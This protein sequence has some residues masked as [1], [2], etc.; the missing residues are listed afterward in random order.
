[1]DEPEQADLVF[2]IARDKAQEDR[3][4]REQSAPSNVKLAQPGVE[5]WT[6]YFNAVDYPNLYV[7]RKFIN[8]GPTGEL[9]CCSEYQPLLEWLQEKG[10]TKL[11][12]HPND[13]PVIVESWL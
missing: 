11:A 5:I 8:A 6:V 1:M 12:R 10:L 9:M 3:A 7:A 2:K 4:T 13:H